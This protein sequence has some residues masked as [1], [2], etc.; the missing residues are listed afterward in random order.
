M[1]LLRLPLVLS[2]LAIVHFSLYPWR[3]DPRGFSHHPAGLHISSNSDRSDVL[4]NLAFYFVPAVLAQWTLA[5]SNTKAF[6]AVILVSGFALLSLTLE[7][8]QLA[9][10]G[11]FSTYRDILCNTLGALCGV[12]TAGVFP[13]PRALLRNSLPPAAIAVSPFFIAWIAWQAFPF[14]PF[15]PLN[16]PELFRRTTLSPVPSLDVALGLLLL[17]LLAHSLRLPALALTAA[18]ALLIPAQ[19]FLRDFTPSSYLLLAAA[20][21]LITA[22]IGLRNPQPG[23]HLAFAVLLTAW[24]AYRELSLNLLPAS[25]SDTLRSLAAQLLLW[26]GSIWLWQRTFFSLSRA[27]IG[28]GALLVLTWIRS[29]NP[30]YAAHLFLLLPA[31]WMVRLVNSPGIATLDN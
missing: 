9:I 19:A 28:L 8:L 24:I 14:I 23:H 10:P 4:V 6:S 16:F 12:L 20:L 2:L 25:E 31:I 1:R 29:A 18:A 7:T 15:L 27:A 30:L 5:G 13:P 21:A 11:R 26:A 3:F 17:Y 22:A